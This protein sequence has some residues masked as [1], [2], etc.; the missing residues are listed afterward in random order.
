MTLHYANLDTVAEITPP[1]QNA[2]ARAVRKSGL[3]RNGFKRILDITLVLLALPILLPL[4][5][6]LLA[7][8]ASDG[9]R[10]FYTQPRIGRGGQVFRIWKLRTMVTGA[11]AR[12]QDYLAQNPVAQIEWDAT[13]KLKVDPRVTRVGRFLRKASIDELPQLWNVFNGSMSLVGPR[14][15]MP[16]QQ[17]AYFGTGYYNLRP[18]ITGAW[19]VSDRNESEFVGRVKHD[20]AYYR[21]VSLKIDASILV[22]TVG[23]VLRCTG[24]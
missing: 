19:Q 10:P 17:E 18:G 8:V 21:D 22:Q 20:D 15:M 1:R 14:P 13:Q 9:H 23:V 3:Y 12:L 11:E 24:Y 4:M 16:S 2:G 7:L 6:V 5:L